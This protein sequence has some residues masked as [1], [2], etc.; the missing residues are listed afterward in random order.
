MSSPSS[1]SISRNNSAQSAAV[2]LYALAN[3]KR[4]RKYISDMSYD[5]T[6]YASAKTLYGD[7]KGI[8]TVSFKHPLLGI[9]VTFRNSEPMVKKAARAELAEIVKK[10][11]DLV[12]PVLFEPEL[13][14]KFPVKF[15]EEDLEN[16]PDKPIITYPD[17][18][19]VHL[20][21]VA[22]I[23]YPLASNSSESNAEIV[24][25]TNFLANFLANLKDNYKKIYA[26]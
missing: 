3:G 1:L 16:L 26:D 8:G 23:L 10:H 25:M 20:S 15:V 24:D 13:I 21:A 9:K 4:T 2:L 18:A 11:L 22:N 5:F 7:N 14:N 12:L 19:E 6:R 17:Y